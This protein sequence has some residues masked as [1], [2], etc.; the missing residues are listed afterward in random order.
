MK[1][2]TF[3]IAIIV[4]AGLFFA[5]FFAS[6]MPGLVSLE[7]NSSRQLNANRIANP[8]NNVS[9]ESNYPGQQVRI[10]V[11]IPLTGALSIQGSIV[12]DGLL[13]ANKQKPVVL[14]RKVELVFENDMGNPS[15]AVKIVNKF[16]EVDGINILVGASSGSMVAVAPIAE[17][18]KVILISPMSATPVLT[19]SGDFVFRVSSSSELMAIKAASEIKKSGIGKAAVLFENVEYAVGWKTVFVKRFE[20]IGGTIAATEGFE[21]GATDIRSQ[22]I[23]IKNTNP[24]AVFFIA[25]GI[26]SAK[27][28]LKQYKEL[29]MRVQLIGN[30]VFGFKSILQEKDLS[31]NM[32]V[33]TYR[34]DLNSL[35]MKK[36]LSEFES[37]FGRQLS[38]EIY[39]ALAY[40]AYNLLASSV[41]ACGSTNAECIKQQLYKI[42][43]YDGASGLFSIDEKG[44][45]IHDFVLRKVKNGEL[46]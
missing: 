23:K 12:R 5:L 20:S 15:E 7:S 31:E 33:L 22:L 40:D 27:N 25:Q 21:A 10:G 46:T 9:L 34:Y 4:V 14:N 42:Q 41:N 16:V 37:F 36:F 8:L 29:N 11:F 38:E 35:K 43:N 17:N 3:A 44:D 26:N 6:G 1:P 2:K 19:N 28:L 18:K 39:G 30:E 45:A 24:E 13:L 32:L